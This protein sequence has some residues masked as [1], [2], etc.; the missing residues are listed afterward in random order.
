MLNLMAAM[1]VGGGLGLGAALLA[2]RLFPSTP[3][4]AA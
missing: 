3:A 2:E 4:D 1:V